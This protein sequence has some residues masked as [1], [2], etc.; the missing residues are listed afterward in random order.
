M[1]VNFSSFTETFQRHE[2]I[3][4]PY[5]DEMLDSKQE[6]TKQMVSVVGMKTING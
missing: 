2:T 6:N 3:V 1:S 4:I 5:L